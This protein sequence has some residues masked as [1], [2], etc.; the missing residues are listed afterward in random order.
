[1][2][3]IHF[4]STTHLP[5]NSCHALLISALRGLAALQV[6]A[7]HLRAQLYPSL[8]SIPDPALWYQVLAFFTGFAHQAV[9][10]FFLLSGWLVGG[11]LLNRI[12]QPHCMLP[13]AID[14]ITR[15]WI[16]LAPAFVL[17]LLLAILMEAADPSRV[18]FASDNP[19]S[20][21]AFAGNLF[22]LQD[23]AVPRFGGN[24]ALWSLAYETWYYVLFPLMLIPFTGASALVRSLAV[25]AAALAA[26]YLS[27]PI[28]LYFG[29]WL[30]GAAFSRVRIDASRG[31][32]AAML[33]LL[34]ALAV[35][36]RLT[37]SNDILVEQS[38]VQDLVYSLAFLVLLSSLQFPIDA[39]RP[40]VRLIRPAAEL[41]A[42]FSFTLYVIHV[43]L[44][45]ALRQALLDDGRLAADD[46]A[47]LLIY[48]A[49][50]VAI[51]M[52]AW[53]FHLPFEAQTVR[54][55]QSIKLALAR[56]RGTRP[57]QNMA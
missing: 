17:T 34:A 7:A 23:L 6:V 32:L 5:C 50:L 35:S 1:M 24:F 43:P 38:F 20:V 39:A 44:L 22:G 26:W 27:L 36:F 21:T 12:G 11:S 2:L 14:R 8:K 33:A 25:A 28:M 31:W 29:V 15:L 37:G 52:L 42:A 40:I 10:I 16:V 3:S 41:L 46:P 49:L 9:V 56:R 53:L 13:Y 57:A 54:L 18:D 55:R 48:F 30:M 19:Y 4:L 51:V 47:S 45:V